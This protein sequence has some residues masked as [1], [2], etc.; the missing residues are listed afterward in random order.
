MMIRPKTRNPDFKQLEAVFQKKVPER[1][2]LF[3]LF[4]NDQL[5]RDVSGMSWNK[6]DSLARDIA[7]IRAN[8]L[9]GYDYAIVLGSDFD[10]PK[11]QRRSDHTISLNEGAIITDRKSFDAYDWPDPDAYDYSR[12]EKLT[13]YLPDGMELMVWSPDGLLELIIRL[14]GYENL[15][16]MLYDDPQLVHDIFEEAG[17]RFTRYF[18]RCLDYKRVVGVV[19]SDDWGFNTQTM[20]SKAHMGELLFPWQS[21]LVKKAHESGRYAILHSCGRFDNI[22]DDII[23]IGFDAKHSYEDNIWPVEQ[24]YEQ[25]QGR[26]GVLGGIDVDFIVRESEDQI[27]SRARDMLDRTADRGGYALGTGNSVPDYVPVENYFSMLKA[28]FNY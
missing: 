14:T 23:Q 10:F 18:E 27:Y 5:I 21:K 24:A 28:A 15:C 9:L 2:V 6:D 22:L 1:P 20:I 8:D 25:M 26:I 12:L 19:S 16:I 4:I 13:D 3:E 7:Y 17:K 11:A